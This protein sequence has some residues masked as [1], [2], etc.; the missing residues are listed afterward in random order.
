MNLF[1]LFKFDE[2]F[3]FDHLNGPILRIIQISI[4]ITPDIIN[5]LCTPS[6]GFLQKLREENLS[7]NFPFLQKE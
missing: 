6:T 7:P 5:V 1:R 4:Q 3:I 2:S